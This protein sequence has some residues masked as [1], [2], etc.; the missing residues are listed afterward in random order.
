M[1]KSLLPI[2]LL[3][4]LMGALAL[5]DD[6]EKTAPLTVAAMATDVKTLEGHEIQLTGT[7][8]GACASGCKMWVADGNYKEG[9]LFTLVRAKDDA[10]KFDTKQQ[11]A[12]V[13]LTGFVVAKYKD[14][15][16]DAAAEGKAEPKEGEQA[17]TCKAPVK[18]ETAT[19]GELQ[20]MTFFAT[21]V[22][23]VKKADA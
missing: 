3:I 10:F 9:D 20:E 2:T 19:T 16:G 13:I 8:V 21:K 7:I 12:Q 5:A 11:G 6:A 18:V 15:C 1:R 14:Y 17:G 22:E 4:C 23:Y